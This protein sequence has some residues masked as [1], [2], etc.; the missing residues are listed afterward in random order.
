MNGKIFA[1]SANI[2]QD[3]AK[4]LFN[5]Y[6]Q[7]A[8]R[9][10]S[11]EE[12]IEQQIA[13]LRA[14]RAE[15]EQK[16]SGAW[17]WLLL[18]VFP[19]FIVK[20]NLQKQI[21][22]LDARINEFANMHNEIF[23]DYKV[24]RLGVAYVPVAEQVQY[25][26]KSFVVDLTNSVSD[27]EV[28]MS[29]SRQTPLLIDTIHSLEQLSKEAPVVET[30]EDSEAITTDD[31][32]LSIQEVKENDYLGA[33][34]RSLRTVAYCMDDL[35]T[36]SVTLPLVLE[37]SE[38]LSELGQYATTNPP[39]GHP[40]V[41]VF[42]KQAY[43][44]GIQRFREI[45]ELK[46]SLSNETT[47]FEEILKGL[48]RAIGHSVQTVARMKVASVDKVVL[49]SNRLLY[50]ILKSPYNH[51][52][53]VLEAEE[54]DRI[55]H[56][57]FDY[58]EAVQGYEP[59]QLRQSSR[60]LYN[61]LSGTWVAEDGSQTVQPFGVHQMYEEIVAP[62]VQNLMAE[63]R[64]ERLK[65]YNHIKDQKV[66]YLN[67]WHQD[68]DAFYRSNRAESADLINL[69]QQTLT[70]YVAAYNNLLALQR[71]EN[72]MSESDDNLDATVVST[73]DNT[74]ETIAAFELQGQEFQKCQEE[75]EDYVERLKED[76]DL[77]AARF[78]HVEYYDGKLRDGYSNSV[79]VA[80]S[81]IH[82][83]DERRRALA[84]VNPKLAK[85]SEMPPEPQVSELAHEHFAMNLPA[86]V[87][88]ALESLN[89]PSDA[90][91]PETPDDDDDEQMP[92]GY[93][94]SY[95]ADDEDLDNENFEDSDDLEDPEDSE[96]SDDFE[97]SDDSENS[98]NSDDNDDSDDDDDYETAEAFIDESEEVFEDSDE[99]S[100]Q[101]ATTGS[102]IPP[103]PPTNDN[104]PA[105]P[106]TPPV[107]PTV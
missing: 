56:E 9:I 52:S 48:M 78:G 3:Q 33:L 70:E 27:S 87:S 71:T 34:E 55:R 58:S 43:A 16:M 61:P 105:T 85:D 45:N 79:A 68:T 26:N 30:S 13:Q 99:F 24:S 67:K 32:S 81:E 35:E 66:S 46:N 84:S 75:F 92:A 36:A 31:Y 8:E 2:W 7:A 95:E 106:P 49:D 107:P 47:Q 1:D 63:N 65:I 73:V 94:E 77:K 10:V 15:L 50:Q 5:Y 51:Y 29:L 12:R 82:L 37:N 69:M 53:P 19:Y 102:V 76:I 100:Q 17:V 80:A 62:I 18:F 74:D 96:S 4:V 22:A 11:E 14:E 20:G 88:A 91:E 101:N 21:D 64:I 72:L 44:P 6:R 59:F 41:E 39:E 83:M 97:N 40:V 28:S 103:A 38:F 54:I 60:V 90:Y 86:M 98:E 93:D 25:Q 42:D 89:A 104:G 57:Q 23:R